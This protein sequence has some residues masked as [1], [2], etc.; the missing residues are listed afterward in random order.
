MRMEE[1]REKKKGAAG[2]C[3]DVIA[4]GRGKLLRR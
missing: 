3:S 1:Q 2:H 4:V